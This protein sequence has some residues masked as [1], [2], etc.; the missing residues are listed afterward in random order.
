MIASELQPI[1]LYGSGISY[2]TG[3]MEMYFRAKGI[4]YQHHPMSNKE[5]TVTIP[6]KT[7]VLQMPALEL[8][9]GR[10]MTDSTPIIA[11]FEEQYPT[12]PV[13]PWDPVQRFFSLLLEDYAD[14][15]LWRPAMHFRWY[16][17]EGAMYAS[18]FLADE[19][20]ADVPGPGFIKRYMLRRRQRGGYTVGDGIT[21]DNRAAVEAIY[22]N[23]LTALEAV[24]QQRP[25]LLGQDPSLVDVGF[26]GSMFRHFSMDPPPAKIMRETAPAVYE[27]IARLWNF[28]A[29]ENQGDWLS[30]IPNDWGF[31]LNDIGSTYLP[32]LNASTRALVEGKKRFDVDLG[33]AHYKGA[34]VAAYRT[35]C[36]EKLRNNFN[37]VPESA[38]AEIRRILEEHGCWQPLWEI[39]TLDSGVDSDNSLPFS[40][41]SK[42]V[43]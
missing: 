10:W 24:L 13:T 27:W 4:P 26:M 33:G 32:Y 23:N 3:K 17:D 8:G 35:W 34:H 18:R 20:M 21:E 6:E 41:G 14:E 7:G 30:G 12:P 37:T 2:F 1:K 29:R 5:F 43:Y 25:F 38:Q 19:V 16:W 31:W 28:S 36:L 9:D 11:W 22:Y 15:W 39:E 42:M 40:G